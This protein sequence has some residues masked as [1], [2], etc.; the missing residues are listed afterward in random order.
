LFW[1]YHGNDEMMGK[2]MMMMIFID[3]SSTTMIISVNIH[4][5][6]LLSLLM[7]M[8]MTTPEGRSLLVESL[9]QAT[10]MSKKGCFLIL[11]LDPSSQSVL[12]KKQPLNI[13][14]YHGF[15]YNFRRIQSFSSTQKFGRQRTPKWDAIL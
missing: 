7:M 1:E 6:I 8:M 11:N 4:Y 5:H 12:F 15:L 2:W 10:W 13:F 14:E 3:N 9:G